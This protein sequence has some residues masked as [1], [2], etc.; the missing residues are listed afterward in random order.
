MSLGPPA[1]PRLI[2]AI[3]GASGTIYGIRLLERLQGSGIETH[4][5]LSQWAA[6]TLVHETTYTVQQVQALASERYAIGDVGAAIASGSFL[7]MGMV[8]VP[9]SMR[10]LGCIA[11]GVGDNLIHR[12]ADVV[13]KERRKLVL[14][15]RE[16]PLSEIHLQNMVT[17]AR[18]G[19]SICPPTPAFYNH[20]QT[21][22]DLVAYSVTRLLDQFGI[23]VP[24]ERWTGEMKPQ[25]LS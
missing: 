1:P 5:V 4:L 23:H 17:L 11:H 9:C 13:L 16:A 14:A 3:T 18:M 10:T 19:V 6:R 22:D 12:A 7:T 8:I 25:R 24:A 15:V 21:I 2:V 20:P